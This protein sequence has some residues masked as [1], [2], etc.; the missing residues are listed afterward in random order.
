MTLENKINEVCGASACK[1]ITTFCISNCGTLKSK[2]DFLS[3]AKDFFSSATWFATRVKYIEI[4]QELFAG[5]IIFSFTL[6]TFISNIKY[7]SSYLLRSTYKYKR[8]HQMRM[9]ILRTFEAKILKYL[10]TL[11]L[12]PKIR[13]SYKKKS[14]L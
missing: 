3:S 10:R 14:V 5:L 13:R 7:R 1:P 9:I 12:G 6:S 8:V 4:L 11:S 2:K